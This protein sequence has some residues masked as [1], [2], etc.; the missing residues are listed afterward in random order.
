[1]DKIKFKSFQII[2]VPNH[3]STQTDVMVYALTEEGDIYFT[4]MLNQHPW[5]KMDMFTDERTQ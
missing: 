4:D 1:M 2:N 5:C 3:S